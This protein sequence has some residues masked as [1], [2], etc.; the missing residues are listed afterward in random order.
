MS[1][2]LA[3][4]HSKVVV[5]EVKSLPDVVCHMIKGTAIVIRQETEVE[6]EENSISWM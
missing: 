6:Q 1:N 3:F 4:E 5:Q 2:Y